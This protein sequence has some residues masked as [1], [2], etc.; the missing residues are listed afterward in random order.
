MIHLEDEWTAQDGIKLYW[1]EWKPDQNH[2]CG[3][4]LLVHGIG[5]HSGRYAHVAQALTDVGYVLLAFDQRGHGRSEGLRG[6]EMM[7]QICSDTSHFLDDA[8]NRYPS[9]PI[10]L[11]GHSLGGALV[12][13]HCI[14]NLP[15]ITGVI[16]TAPGLAADK[17]ISPMTIRLVKILAR[18]LPKTQIDNGLNRNLL[19]RDPQVIERYNN[20]PLVHGKVTARLGF[21]LLRVGQVVRES[22][23]FPVP[24]LLIVGSEDKLIDA[25]VIQEFGKSLEGDV[26]VK[27]WDGLYHEVHNEP[28]QDQV[29]DFMIAWMNR[30]AANGK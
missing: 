11:Y 1:Q 13:Y 18:V 12:L 22:T 21:D 23:T 29:F 15:N 7:G 10:F 6:D 20:D 3:I 4:V 30:V 16:A 2:P 26:T 5:E 9:L 14:A 19:S 17:G 25:K 28:E 24:L 27:V 8:H